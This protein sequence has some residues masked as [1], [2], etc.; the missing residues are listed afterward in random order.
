MP[1]VLSWPSP[2]N[3][4]AQL[5]SRRGTKQLQEHPYFYSYS[6]LPPSIL[7]LRSIHYLCRNN[8]AGDMIPNFKSCLYFQF[9]PIWEQLCQ[10]GDAYTSAVHYKRIDFWPRDVVEDPAWYKNMPSRRKLRCVI[11][12][13]PQSAHT[14]CRPFICQ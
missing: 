8:G 11:F 10:T 4:V 7:N 12:A 6:S 5:R 3:W 14:L 13:P 1:L 9:H 2:S